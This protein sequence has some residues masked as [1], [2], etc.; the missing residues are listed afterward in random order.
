MLAFLTFE[1][2][3]LGLRRETFTEQAI[4]F[5]LQPEKYLLVILLQLLQLSL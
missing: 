1:I 5:F 4:Q 2:M 3:E